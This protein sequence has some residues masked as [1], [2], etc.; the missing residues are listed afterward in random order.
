MLDPQEFDQF[1]R[2]TSNSVLQSKIGES[3]NKTNPNSLLQSTIKSPQFIIPVEKNQ[4]RP[5][6]EKR[7]KPIE[8]ESPSFQNINSATTISSSSLKQL[9]NKKTTE[10]SKNKQI[11]LKINTLIGELSKLMDKLEE[12]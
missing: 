6:T 8:S 10:V 1:Y 12:H 4:Q 9:I 3:M 7:R 5:T 11:Y 2:Q